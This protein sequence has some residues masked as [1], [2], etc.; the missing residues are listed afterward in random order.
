[1]PNR[2]KNS[3]SALKK[4]DVEG[5]ELNYFSLVEL[6]KQGLVQLSELPFSIRILLE[7]L[8]RNEDGKLVSPE[9]II[10]VAKYNPKFYRC[11]GSSR[12]GSHARGY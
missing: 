1:M 5:E 11:P 3:F 4:L 7:N 6:E 9:A 8:L 2:F 12:P 10:N